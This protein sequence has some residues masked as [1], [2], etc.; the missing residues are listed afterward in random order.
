MSDTLMLLSGGHPVHRAFGEAIGADFFQIKQLATKDQSAPLKAYNFVKAALSIPSGY[1]Y[2]LCESCYFYPALKR[3]MGLLDKSKIININCGPILQHIL[4][5]RVMGL[6]AKMLKSLLKEVDGHLVYGNFGRDLLNKFHVTTPIRII[7][8]LVHSDLLN[9]L[10][11]VKPNLDSHKICVIATGDGYNKGL[12]LLFAAV[13]EVSKTFPDASVD[14][15]TKMSDGE[16]Q[17]LNKSNCPVR[18]FRNV[19][20]IGAILS[21][22]ALYVQPSRSDMFP[23]S[24]VEAMAA[25]LLVIVSN[26][27]GTADLIS[28][29]SDKSVVECNVK[30]LTEAILIHFN[31][32]KKSKIAY[33]S[34]YRDSALSF[35][36]KIVLDLFRK[37]Y[38]YLLK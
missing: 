32:S 28:K 3:R 10:I 24:V 26:K 17:N 25:G 16:I 5:G 29:L 22:S 12:D 30:D 1:K 9:T 23:T 14:L 35:D 33:S 38:S 36:E 7:Y 27:T 6:E 21:H 19:N 4:N 37:Q 20:D 31:M 13:S 8:P 18:I 34:K 2:I 11:K 15:I